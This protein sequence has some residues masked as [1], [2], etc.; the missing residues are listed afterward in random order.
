MRFD[1][2]RSTDRLKSTARSAVSRA[3]VWSR[4]GSRRHS[5]ARELSVVVPIYNVEKYLAECLDSLL[6]Q[7]FQPFEVIV[8][9]DGSPDNS[10]SIAKSYASRYS[11]VRVFNQDNAGLGAA[12][13][14]GARLAGGEYLAF[15][16]SDDTLPRSAFANLVGALERSNSDFAVGSLLRQVGARY[17]EPP[18]AKELHS[19]E[20][21]H[22]TLDDFPEMIADITST[23][24]VFRRT[25]W[26]RYQLQFSEG[27]S[28][29]DYVP[30]SSAYLLA[31]G[32]DVIVPS[33][34]NYRTR[35]DASSITQQKHQVADLRERFAAKR[36]TARVFK[37]LGSQRTTDSW[38]A[39]SINYDMP[40]YYLHVAGADSEYWQ[41]L[42]EGMYELY[43]GASAPALMAVRVRHR[44]AAWLAA[45]GYR[46]ELEVLLRFLADHPYDTPVEIREGHV[47]ACMPYLD[48]SEPAVPE[49]VFELAESETQLQSRLLRVEWEGRS[50]VL[51]GWSFISGVPISASETLRVAFVNEAIG[52]ELDAEVTTHLDPEA[53][54]WARTH[55]HDYEESAFEA[56]IDS[57]ALAMFSDS[58]LQDLWWTV[59]LERAISGVYRQGGFTS[60]ARATGPLLGMASHHHWAVPRYGPDGLSIRVRQVT[61]RLVGG[62]VSDNTVTARVEIQQTDPPAALRAGDDIEVSFS[63]L[64]DHTFEASAVVPE[65]TRTVRPLH[66]V[67]QSGVA[68]PVAWA[69]DASHLSEQS[70][71]PG[72]TLRRSASGRAELVLV[73]K[74]V[75]I[76]S[77]TFH[78]GAITVSGHAVGLQLIRYSLAGIRVQT[79]TE[80]S[81]VSDN[82][83]KFDI[84]FGY[85][86]WKLGATALPADELVLR[87]WDEDGQTIE[88]ALSSSARRALPFSEHHAN[89]HIKTLVGPSDNVV[90]AISPPLEFSEKGPLAQRRLQ[91]DIYP[92]AR[93]KSPRPAALFVSY[94]GKSASCN[95][96]GLCEELVRRN[97]ELDLVWSVQD[98][99]VNVPSGTRG[100]LHGSREWYELLGTA[101]YLVNNASFPAFF[102]KAPH[103]IHV[104][105]WHGAALKRIGHDAESLRITMPGYLD[106]MDAEAAAWDYLI[107][108]SKFCSDIFPR[109]FRYDGPVLELGYPRNDILFSPSA[110]TI[111]A[112]T[113]S[114][115]GLTDEQTVVLYAPTFRDTSHGNRGYEKVVYLDTQLA[116]DCLDDDN[117]FFLVRGHSNTERSAHAQGTNVLD[118]TSYPDVNHL[119]LA[120]DVLITDYSSVMFDFNLTDKPTLF[121]VPDLDHYRDDVRGFYFE[122]EE[123]APGPLLTTTE[124]V[125]D[126]IR[127]LA[128]SRDAANR[129]RFRHEF[130][131]FDDGGASARA[132]DA[133]FR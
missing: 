132:V 59:R 74:A 55:W 7:T 56:R 99:S 130:M 73:S 60:R 35:I 85:D 129:E 12:R 14:V 41:I 66:T 1:P 103:Q 29:E 120:A 82:Y 109:A 37:E 87:L 4:R 117:V 86:P 112:D 76:D 48:S 105:T 10:A 62:Q 71:L 21:L 70:G 50:L 78:S 94:S 38:Y 19:I 31:R 63:P 125:V 119:Y 67:D 69:L 27:V 26:E 61:A 24:K 65:G 123:W 30:V 45:H 5:G 51:Q 110:T 20:R 108:P 114:R 102:R 96:L 2:A 131:P 28:Y 91:H 11:H 95:P 23:N 121:L 8:V 42:S 107:S 90:I 17:L 79:A 124:E 133:I 115:L 25:F 80:R 118:V 40:S 54:T 52:I 46:P 68:H 72:L 18:W 36:R 83:F 39:S 13:N 89:A 15:V 75:T 98:H 58:G 104:Q 32:F 49:Y 57:D 122:L 81:A 53:A 9:N 93:R 97:T 16:D 92:T 47:L 43:S 127:T 128:P 100:V 116:S 101:E 33:V 113:R 3:K 64:N 44:L 126:T 111:R 22:V 84:P 34:Y 106:R 77:I 6:S 88:Y